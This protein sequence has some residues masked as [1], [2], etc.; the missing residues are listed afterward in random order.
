MSIWSKLINFNKSGNQNNVTEN[1]DAPRSTPDY[2]IIDIEFGLSDK[3]IHDIGAL[4]IMAL[5][6]TRLQKKSYSLS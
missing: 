5:Y 6:S 4:N 2:A 3:R 1:A